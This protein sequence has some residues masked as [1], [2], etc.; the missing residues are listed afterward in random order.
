MFK[1]GAQVSHPG[2]G[3]CT[4]L[5]KCTLNLTGEPI[6]YYKLLPYY[7]S[8]ETVYTPV[9]NAEKIGVR[10][11]VTK[12]QA[13]ELLHTLGGT[14]EEWHSDTQKKQQRCI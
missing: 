1:T 7:G 11:L 5:D 8:A 10:K 9:A 4:V 6:E 14:A 13:R 2:H 12:D 3:A